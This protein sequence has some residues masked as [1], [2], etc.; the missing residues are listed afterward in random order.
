MRVKACSVAWA[1]LRYW[2]VFWAEADAGCWLSIMGP[3]DDGGMIA[4]RP[5]VFV[6]RGSRRAVRCGANAMSPLAPDE[7]TAQTECRH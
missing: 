2:M 5:G 3:L 6:V 1:S 7:R 4:V